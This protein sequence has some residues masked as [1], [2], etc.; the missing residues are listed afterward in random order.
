MPR[1]IWEWIVRMDEHIGD[2]MIDAGVSIT[3]AA[4][5]TGLLRTL[6]DYL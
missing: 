6:L 1:A 3:L 2:V 4:I 5:A